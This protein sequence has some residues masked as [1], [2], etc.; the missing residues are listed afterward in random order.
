MDKTPQNY[1]FICAFDRVFRYFSTLTI[2]C[3]KKGEQILCL[4]LQLHQI[5]SHSLSM[6]FPTLFSFSILWC[7]WLIF[8]FLPG[9]V[10]KKSFR[11]TV[12]HPTIKHTIVLDLGHRRLLLQGQTSQ[13]TQRIWRRFYQAAGWRNVDKQQKVIP[14]PKC[15]ENVFLWIDSGASSSRYAKKLWIHIDELRRSMHRVFTIY[16][17]HSYSKYL[18]EAS[19]ITLI[20]RHVNFCKLN[21]IP[22]VRKCHINNYFF[23][24]VFVSDT[25]E[26]IY[27]HITHHRVGISWC[28]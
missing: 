9:K 13:T 27:L 5:G 2:V 1:L 11:R 26:Q 14:A 25:K 12:C 23:V 7:V 8:R 6:R 17:T 28:M 15:C 10:R 18:R 21:A 24:Y 4:W 19:C 3:N 16:L 22:S 20:F